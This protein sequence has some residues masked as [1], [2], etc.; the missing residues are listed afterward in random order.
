M[1]DK[2]RHKWLELSEAISVVRN[3]QD[4]RSTAE[5]PAGVFADRLAGIFT[6]AGC[7]VFLIEDEGTYVLAEAGFSAAIHKS[8]YSS[9]MPLMRRFAD[10]G[11]SFLARDRAAIPP[12]AL[13]R[14]GDDISSV[15][16]C[17]VLSGG[18]PRGFIYLCSSGNNCFSDDDL[19]LAELAAG[20]L[21][22]LMTISTLEKTVE[23]LTIR[24]ALTGCLN[25]KKF[26]EDIEIDIPCA[27]RYGKALSLLKLDIDFLKTYNDANGRTNGDT[28]LSKVGETLA[29]S[30]RKCD[31]LYRYSGDEFIIT[32]PG[33]DKERAVFTANRLQKVLGQLR[34][35]GM[36][37]DLPGGKITFSIGVASF[38]SDSVFKDGLIRAVDAALR[39]ARESGG[40]KVISSA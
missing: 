30:I 4:L 3:D 24:D 26:D 27:E 36:A 19:R 39:T 18:V 10:S 25:H 38:P 12:E 7:S 35:E 17:P 40:D 20:E 34:F 9:S 21:S 8:S 16:C 33:I 23:S 13:F 15:L 2:Q 31:R 14:P 22:M 29:Y 32:L 11:K 37:P 28:V 6:P 5:G 1:P